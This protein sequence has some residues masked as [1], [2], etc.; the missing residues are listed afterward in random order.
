MFP[1][2]KLPEGLLEIRQKHGHKIFRQHLTEKVNSLGVTKQQL[3][4]G[5]AYKNGFLIEKMDQVI[6]VLFPNHDIIMITGTSRN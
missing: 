4:D 5:F 3:E 6:K 1:G 2:G